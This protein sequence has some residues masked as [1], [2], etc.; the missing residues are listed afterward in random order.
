[1]GTAQ[2]TQ[3]G[4]GEA[5]EIQQEAGEATTT[6]QGALG[7]AKERIRARSSPSVSSRPS[8]PAV[9]PPRWSS[10]S[11]VPTYTTMTGTRSSPDAFRLSRARGGGWPWR[12]R[13]DREGH[14]KVRRKLII[15]TRPRE[16][17]ACYA[18]HCFFRV[19]SLC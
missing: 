5:T 13:M 15:Q 11:T 6:Y 8:K 16:P 19:I 1:M 12:A 14:A 3:S 9:A 10:A 4:A 17:D 18:N 2:V 7:A